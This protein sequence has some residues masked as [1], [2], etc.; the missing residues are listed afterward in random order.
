MKMCLNKLSFQNNDL[1]EPSNMDS[2]LVER[3]VNSQT[4]KVSI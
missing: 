2:M 4:S 3:Q 1:G